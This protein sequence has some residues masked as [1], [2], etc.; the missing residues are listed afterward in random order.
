LNKIKM[1][2]STVTTKT[3]SATQLITELQ[4]HILKLSE[5]VANL[6]ARFNTSGS[7]DNAVVLTTQFELILQNIDN[8]LNA[9]SNSAAKVTKA[10]AVKAAKETDSAKETVVVN[11]PT[12]DLWASEQFTTNTVF[13]ST[14]FTETDLAS[15]AAD[16]EVK[17]KK[18]QKAKSE[19]TFKY[20]WANASASVKE[21]I[22]TEYNAYLAE[23]ATAE[24]HV[25]STTAESTPATTTASTSAPAKPKGKG[26]GKA[27]VDSTSETVETVV[28]GESELSLTIETPKPK[29]K[30]KGKGKAE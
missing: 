14:H 19:A 6:T 22:T 16:P 20:L 18:A 11:A 7:S 1:S 17:K 12:V 30:G 21:A 29:G 9:L 28:T 24:T 26:K 4:G 2:E 10:P 8:K 27:V 5:S 3:T 15:A 25:D 13:A 23:S